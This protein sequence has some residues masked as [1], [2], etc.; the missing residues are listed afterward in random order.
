MRLHG[1]T[2]VITG[3]NRGIGKACVEKMASEGVN[4]WA[5]YRTKNDEFERYLSEIAE[6]NHIII[7]SLVFDMTDE[8]GMKAAF[9]TIRKTKEPVD[10]L[11]NNAGIVYTGMYQMTDVSKAQELFEINA[12]AGMRLTQYILKLMTRQKSG[13]IINIASSGGIDC[14][15]G[16]VAYNMSKAAVIAATKTLAAEV[17]NRGIRV[18][19]IAPG[20][21]ET[22]MAM[23]N[24][25]EDVM[26]D[27][28]RNTALGRMGKPEEIAN[29]VSFLASDE[30]SYVTGQ[31]WRV[32]GG[33]R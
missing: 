18:N 2:A 30:A 29:V 15:P 8:E 16:R 22:D 5:C 17:G 27:T 1:K 12:C 24:T 14:N 3:C 10:I 4:I 6:K 19:A 11:V 33:M 32:D 31:V 9:E 23:Q 25:P 20:L 26:N 13:S 21:T 28:I 7:R